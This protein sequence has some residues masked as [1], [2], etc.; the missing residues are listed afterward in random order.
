MADKKLLAHIRRTKAKQVNKK[1][2]AKEVSLKQTTA[3]VG[4]VNMEGEFD[5]DEA[6]AMEFDDVDGGN[7]SSSDDDETSNWVAQAKS[8][9]A[10]SSSGWL[11]ADTDNPLDLLDTTKIAG[12]IST[13]NPV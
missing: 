3:A 4:D 10:R 13:N 7:S 8:A 5:N 1:L 11:K 6:E 12:G 2:R 9:L